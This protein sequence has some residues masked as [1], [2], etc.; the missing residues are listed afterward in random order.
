MQGMQ[1][2]S[3]LR[4]YNR[5]YNRLI[6][7][8]KT[9]RL[10]IGQCDL[11][12]NYNTV[13]PLLCQYCL[14][15]LAVFSYPVA[16]SN[17]LHWPIV[18]QLFPRRYFDQLYCFSPYIWP[19]D[20]WLKQLKY[21]NRFELAMMLAHLIKSLWIERIVPL[22]G[23]NYTLTAVPIH[24]SQ[25]QQRG[26]NQAHLIARQLSKCVSA[27]YQSDLLIR[28]QFTSS[29]VGQTGQ[30]RRKNL[31][32]AFAINPTVSVMPRHIIIL[33][34]VITTG[35]TVNVISQL[36]KQRGVNAI[37]VLTLALTLPRVT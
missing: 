15:D 23:D 7:Q 28:T 16:G 22:L 3:K 12:H 11:C 24:P 19:M 32:T 1:G 14:A 10:A 20:L 5:L 18:N 4:L 34:D 9:W 2:I 33:D 35:S 17:L 27:H 29:Q 13:Q 31:Q 6:A 37:T 26:Y 21:H 25:W 36:L 8:F 30:Q